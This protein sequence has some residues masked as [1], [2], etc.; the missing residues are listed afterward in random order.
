MLRLILRHVGSPLLRIWLFLIVLPG[1]VYDLRLVHVRHF[2]VYAVQGLVRR[3][4]CMLCDSVHPTL[5]ILL[6]MGVRKHISAPSQACPDNGTDHQPTHAGKAPDLGG[7]TLMLLGV[8][9]AGSVCIGCV[10]CH[11][12]AGRGLITVLGRPAKHGPGRCVA[13]STARHIAT[14]LESQTSRHSGRDQGR[15]QALTWG[16]QALN[17]R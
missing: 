14:P 15:L 4:R 2:L 3:R 17:G 5:I 11:C 7:G 8:L 1:Q 10:L 16:R 6:R 9:C 12:L 13:R